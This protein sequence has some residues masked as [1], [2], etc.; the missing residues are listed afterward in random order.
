MTLCVYTNAKDK[1][2]NLSA[3]P[4]DKREEALT[5]VVNSLLTIV[6]DA[7]ALALLKQLANKYPQV[8]A[9][10]ISQGKTDIAELL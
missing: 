5:N 6:G 9:I 3:L 10:V 2:S 8:K 4:S 1:A 7:D